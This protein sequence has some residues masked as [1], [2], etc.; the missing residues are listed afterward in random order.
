MAAPHSISTPFKVASWDETTLQQLDTTA[1][2]TRA[3]V[4]FT[5]TDTPSLTASTIQADYVMSHADSGNAQ[6]VGFARLVGQWDGKEAS[7]VLKELGTYIKGTG[8]SS[9]L[10]VVEGSGRGALTGATGQGTAKAGHGGGLIELTLSL[11]A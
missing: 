10:T 3:T 5:I 9:E 11:A 7:M 6:Y 1:K 8:S 2:L 4:S